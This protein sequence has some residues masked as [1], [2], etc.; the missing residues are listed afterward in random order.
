MLRT[1][2][3]NQRRPLRLRIHPPAAATAEARAMM[4]FAPATSG[5][6]RGI[7]ELFLQPY[8]FTHFIC[9]FHAFYFD[10]AYVAMATHACFKCMFHMFYLF[11][12]ILQMY[13]TN[14]S[15][16]DVCFKCFIWML[17]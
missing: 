17:Q 14:V 11:R 8:V 7:D 3:P 9:I 6:L 5:S 16:S 4:S 12:R 1:A 10:V 15:A 2:C 13:V